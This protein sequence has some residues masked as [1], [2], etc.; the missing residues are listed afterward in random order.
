MIVILPSVKGRVRSIKKIFRRPVIGPHQVYR[1]IRQS[2][3]VNRGLSV[4]RLGDVM[5]KLL[6]R[7]DL[8][9][10]REVSQFLGIPFPPPRQLH[11]D[12]RDS[13]IKASIVGVTHFPKR[14][15]IQTSLDTEA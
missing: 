12:L 14:M 10:L 3:A 7:R 6:S 9:T 13:V 4:I 11:A 8:S 1:M 15:Q 5:A 2:I